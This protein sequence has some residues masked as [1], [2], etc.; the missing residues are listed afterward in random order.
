MPARTD[1][2]GA[3]WARFSSLPTLQSPTQQKLSPLRKPLLHFLP[4]PLA[5]VAFRRRSLAERGAAPAGRFRRPVRREV[6]GKS[7]RRH[8]DRLS[9]G[10]LKGGGLSQTVPRLIPGARR[11][12]V[13]MDQPER[14][15]SACRLERG[16][17]EAQN[18]C[19]GRF[20]E[21]PYRTTRLA[22][23]ERPPPL[24]FCEGEK[25]WRCIMTRLASAAG[26]RT[27]VPKTTTCRPGRSAARS[28]ALLTRDP[29]ERFTP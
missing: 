26:R 8:Y 23:V 5:R 3:A 4:S 16:I 25:K 18:R 2:G 17:R 28:G 9:R 11:G 1:G 12:M 6:P 10:D 7:A 29:G 13:R 27:R 21:R 22:F 24:V 14:A 15:P 19:G 20:D